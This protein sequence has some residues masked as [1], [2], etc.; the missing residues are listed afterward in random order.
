MN[1]D[2]PLKT[3]GEVDAGPLI[4]TVLALGEDAWFVA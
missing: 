2:V 3:L 4:D 1:I